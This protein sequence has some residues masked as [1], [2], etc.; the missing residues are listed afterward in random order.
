[1]NNISTLLPMISID[2]DSNATPNA[3]EPAD[4]SKDDFAS[5][6]AAMWSAPLAQQPQAVTDTPVETDSTTSVGI[7]CPAGQPETTNLTPLP[8]GDI[9]VPQPVLTYDDKPVTPEITPEDGTKKIALPDISLPKQKGKVETEPTD[10]EPIVIS[11]TPMVSNAQPVATTEAKSE[12]PATES[13][14]ASVNG[15]A[16][17]PL[18]G[19][20]PAPGEPKVV[21]PVRRTPTFVDPQAVASANDDTTTAQST[22]TEV[23][24]TVDPVAKSETQPVP[25]APDQVTAEAIKREAN[26]AASYLAQASR[27]NRES[28]FEAIKAQVSGGG[29]DSRSNDSAKDLAAEAKQ[30]DT[31][32][33]VNVS[34]SAFASTLKKQSIDTVNETIAPQVANQIAEL[35]ANTQPRQQRS[36]R[37]RLRPEE[38][39]QVDIQLSRD[40]AGKVSAQVVVE[41]DSARAALSQSLPQLRETLE[42]AGLQVDRLN[43]SSD[44]SSFAGNARDNQQT[45]HQSNRSS[46]L[47]DTSTN[48]SET[49]SQERVRDHKLLSLSA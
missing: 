46:Y 26:L 4:S 30:A 33:P 31:V 42:R 5:M 47:T 15:F 11:Q 49:Q 22:R 13:P 10:A 18:D 7:E 36:V 38:L 19:T 1:M 20:V 9:L 17:Q 24:V 8:N 34:S 45:T 6:L 39:G 48:T 3:P 28:T 37:L 12:Q 40:A 41:R 27:D 44:S 2:F 14:V 35:A 21:A 16:R 32:V 43:V 23:T 29:P 25:A